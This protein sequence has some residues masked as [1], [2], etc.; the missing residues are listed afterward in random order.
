[1]RYPVILS[2]L[3]LTRVFDAQRTTGMGTVTVTLRLS[4][5]SRLG[6][7]LRFAVQPS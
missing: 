7:S 1:V 5:Q 6:A 3:R 4:T 2:S